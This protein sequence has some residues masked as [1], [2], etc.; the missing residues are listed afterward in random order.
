[1]I[2]LSFTYASAMSCFIDLNNINSIQYSLLVIR[3]VLCMGQSWLR[4]DKQH[5]FA[6]WGG[7][8][9]IRLVKRRTTG[10]NIST[11][12]YAINHENSHVDSHF[13]AN[14]SISPTFISKFINDNVALIS[15][16]HNNGIIQAAYFAGNLVKKVFFVCCMPFVPILIQPVSLHVALDSS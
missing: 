13:V 14:P 9:T 3:R 7:I 11:T 16:D 6:Q 8:S 5:S 1:M 2:L 10:K 12:G 4:T 15:P